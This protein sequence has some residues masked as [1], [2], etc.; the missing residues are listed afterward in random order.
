MPTFRSA[1]F[2]LGA[3]AVLLTGPA[4][5][6]AVTD[7]Q[8]E[9]AMRLID[10]IHVTDS[11]ADAPIKDALI[12]E[13]QIV[14]AYPNLADRINEIVQEEALSL[15]DRFQAFKGEAALIYAKAFTEEELKKLADFFATD[16]GQKM[17]NEQE[18]MYRE[19]GRAAEI[20]REGFRKDLAAA[21]Q[22]RVEE[23]VG[24]QKSEAPAEASEAPAE[25][26]AEQPAN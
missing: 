16:V 13:S 9:Q 10:A 5:A 4:S 1:M 24:S 2:L 17:L 11:F 3:L 6:Q 20:W 19:V 26:A 23:I 18:I 12:I 22:S 15:A 8:K 25:G 21:V 14:V 7:G